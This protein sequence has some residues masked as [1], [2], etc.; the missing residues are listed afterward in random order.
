MALDPGLYSA[1]GAVIGQYGI[2]LAEF[3]DLADANFAQSW[4]QRYMVARIQMVPDVSRW[5]RLLR[6]FHPRRL[7][8]HWQDQFGMPLPKLYDSEGLS[9]FTANWCRPIIEVYGSLLAGQKPMPF[10]LDVKAM[11]SMIPSEV[12]RADAQGKL[13]DMELDNQKIP[14]HFLDFCVGVMMFGISYVWSWLDR[15]TRRL[16]TQTIQWPGDVLAQWGSNRYGSGSEGLESVIMVERM[17]IDTARRIY[18]GTEFAPSWP[19]ITF[20]PD[21]YNQMILPGG[22]TQ[23]LKSWWRWHDGRKEQ[24]GYSEVAYNGTN[25][26]QPEVLFRED[27]TGYPDIPLRWASRFHT[28]GEPPHRSAGVLDDIIG[29]NTEYNERLAAFSDILMKYVYPKLAGKGFNQL[30]VPVLNRLQNII[31]LTQAQDLKIIQQIEQ[32]GQSYFDSFLGRLENFMF[33]SAGLSRLVMGSMPP[34]ETSGEALNNLLHSSIARLEVVRTPIQ[35]AWLSLMQEIWVPLLYEYGEYDIPHHLTG[36]P[37]HVDLKMLFDTFSGFTW[38][39]PDVTPRDALRAV[40]VAMELRNAGLLSDET[41]MERARVGSVVDELDKIKKD[42]QDPILHPDRVRLTKMVEMMSA[43]QQQAS[44][45]G[46]VKIS[47]SGQL[48]P[49]EIQ[50][51]AQM[52]GVG[53]AAPQTAGGAEKMGAQVKDETRKAKAAGEAPT[54]E[55]QNK[56]GG[57]VVAKPMAGSE[58]NARQGLQAGTGEAPGQSL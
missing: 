57:G 30:N 45:Q 37:N 7:E 10:S 47:L 53:G 54:F 43:P 24:I 6:F 46:G 42:N 50:E 19:D 12:F 41:A 25:S 22:T 48:S 58:E 29:V 18:P 14:L 36:K 51:A 3:Q 31:P 44:T 39:W 8:D 40:Q 26:G 52:A 9:V 34:G 27:E 49:E 38:T 23:I 33:T 56:R 21:T 28:P 17:P 4:K 13:I 5:L 32:G 35:W 1:G 55:N 16:K 20:R 15:D 2:P 11:D